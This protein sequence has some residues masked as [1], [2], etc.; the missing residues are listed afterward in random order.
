MYRSDKLVVATNTLAEDDNDLSTRRYIRDPAASGTGRR[1]KL[2]PLN[3]I[4][5]PN[6]PLSVVYY[7]K[8]STLHWCEECEGYTDR[9]SHHITCS[10]ARH[11]DPF[12]SGAL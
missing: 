1:G 12:D 8:Y 10:K 4:R 11:S 3:A 9:E 5:V 6:H 7:G 2:L